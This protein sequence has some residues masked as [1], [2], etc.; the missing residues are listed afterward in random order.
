MEF[1][2]LWYLLI[3]I[4][5]VLTI[6]GSVVKI[7]IENKVPVVLTLHQLLIDFLVSNLKYS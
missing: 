5:D 7:L 1:V 6:I 4:N 3:I 2:D